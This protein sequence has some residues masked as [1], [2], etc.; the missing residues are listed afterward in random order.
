MFR[1]ITWSSS[2]SDFQFLWSCQV[3][4]AGNPSVGFWRLTVVEELPSVYRTDARACTHTH[5]YLHASASMGSNRRTCNYFVDSSGQETE[6]KLET[7]W[8]WRNRK[9][10][11]RETNGEETCK[12]KWKG[13][14]SG[15]RRSEEDRSFIS[16]SRTDGDIDRC[17]A[18]SQ[19]VAAR[20]A[21]ATF[22]HL[23]LLLPFQRQVIEGATKGMGFFS[24]VWLPNTL[25][26]HY[27]ISVFLKELPVMA[28]S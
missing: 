24:R 25:E 11:S 14:R 15:R 20:Q 10:G 8:N 27:F 16:W 13:R 21:S 4:G 3:G 5:T 2:R 9:R 23:P 18:T 17:N 6:A 22:L 7:G 1:N 19:T 28:P 12:Q 26:I